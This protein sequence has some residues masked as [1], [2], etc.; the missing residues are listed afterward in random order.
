[1]RSKRHRMTETEGRALVESWRDSGLGQ[2]EFAERRGVK[3]ARIQYWSRRLGGS[4]GDATQSPFFVV[5]A[6]EN[7][8]EPSECEGTRIE[9]VVDD[10]FFLSVPST[11]ENL[12]VLL[13]AMVEAGR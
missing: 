12:G 2:H 8:L 9:L 6:S 11:A 5:T 10:R 4:G 3:V 1:M 13:R 7:E